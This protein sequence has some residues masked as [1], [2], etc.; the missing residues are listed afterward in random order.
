MPICITTE[1]INFKCKRFHLGRKL[2]FQYLLALYFPIFF[3]KF[4]HEQL[5]S[6]E[7][8]DPNELPDSFKKQIFMSK[9]E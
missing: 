9:T 5:S 1:P 8:L 6:L 3:K 7:N 2:K 4:T